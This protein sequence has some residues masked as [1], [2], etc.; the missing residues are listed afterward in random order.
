MKDKKQQAGSLF[1]EAL[2]TIHKGCTLSKKQ[3]S[4]SK[5]WSHLNLFWFISFFGQDTSNTAEPDSSVIQKKI[6][7]YWILYGTID[8]EG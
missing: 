1:I 2:Y 3:L 4:Q 6:I 5:G 7:L 8:R